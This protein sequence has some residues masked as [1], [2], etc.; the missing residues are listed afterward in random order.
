[1]PAVVARLRLA[2]LGVSCGL[3]LLTLAGPVAAQVPDCTGISDVSGFD[4]PGQSD[5]DGQ[6]TTVRLVSGLTMPVTVVSPPDGPDGPDDRLFIVEQPGTIRIYLL[7]FG[8]L[9]PLPFLDIQ[10]RVLLGSF[11]NTEQGLLGLAFHPEYSTPGSPNE[12]VFFVHYTNND[13]NNQI[14]RFRIT[15]P[16]A[17]DPDSEELVLLVPHPGQNNHNGGQLAF[18]PDGRLYGAFGDGG[19]SCDVS[20]ASQDPHDIRGTL[21]RLDVDALPYTT[22]G[23]PFD[24]MDGAP[25]VWAWGLRNPWRFSF[26]RLTGALYIADVGQ[27]QL[28]EIDCRPPSSIGGENYGWVL[29]EGTECPNPSCGGLPENCGTIVHTPPIHEYDHARDGFSCAIAGGYVYRG[30]RMSDLHGTYFYADFC[31]ANIRSFR[32]DATCPLVTQ[33]INRTADLDP[34]GPQEVS[35]IP[36]F[37]EDARGELYVIDRTNG[38]VFKVLPELSIMEVSGQGATPLG[39]DDTGFSWEDLRATSGHLIDQYRIYR[40]VND[41]TGTFSCVHQ[42]G[43]TSWDGGDPEDPQAGE[44]FYYLISALNDLRVETRAGYRSDGTVRVVDTTSVCP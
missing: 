32:T 7:K 41:A 13:G 44:C 1:M 25:E 27:A 2:T 18:G 3:A 19:G 40:S 16:Q 8:L 21:V 9:N 17:A 38:E 22:E 20:G 14:S 36:G 10:D 26:D 15:Q 11:F 29:Y 33:E 12:G 39:V 43:L 4:G 35:N 24:G 42:T 5:F 37:G 31:S 34:P 6:L 23:N 28:E 30:C